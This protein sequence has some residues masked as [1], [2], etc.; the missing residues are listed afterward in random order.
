[1]CARVLIHH[2]LLHCQDYDFEVDPSMDN[3][4]GADGVEGEI[5]KVKF[6]DLVKNFPD[7]GVLQS[8]GLGR[9]T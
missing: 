1:M 6:E 9:L 7:V 4:E 5:S 2:A 3:V 8:T